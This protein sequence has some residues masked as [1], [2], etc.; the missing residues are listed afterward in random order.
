MILEKLTLDNFGL[1]RGE[2][3]LNLAPDSQN[4][5]RLPI[6]LFGGI[7]GGGKTTLLDAV[8][9]VLYGS[10][11]NYSKRSSIAYDEFLRGS[12]NR[13]V[14]LSTGASVT[15]AFRITLD[16]EEHAYEVRRAW[17]QR[18]RTLRERTFVSKDG[19]PDTY[20]ADH[21]TDFVEEAI[22]LGVSQ[23]F[24]FDAEQVRFL[25]DDDTAQASLGGAIKSLLGLDLAERL[26]TD[27]AVLESRFSVQTAGVDDDPAVA[28]F[29]AEI[30]ALVDELV[31]KKAERAGLENNRQRAENAQAEAEEAF[32]AIGGKHWQQ[33]DARRL[34]L[35][36]LVNRRGAIESELVQLAAGALPLCLIPE[37][38]D[39]VRE[40]DLRE[41]QAAEH[42]VV[43]D[44]LAQRDARVLESLAEL[45]VANAAVKTVRKVLDADRRARR[46]ESDVPKWVCFSD[47]ARGQLHVLRDTQMS[48][49]QEHVAKLLGQ[50]EA[51][52]RDV[53]SAEHSL[54]A[55]PDDADV[56]EYV[57]RLQETTKELAVLN[58]RA[59]RLDGEIAAM[60]TQRDGL[61]Q[62]LLA[63]RRERV[64]LELA[65]EQAAR[66]VK[67]AVRTQD[68][69]RKF[70][71][72]ATAA[73]IDRLSHRVT[74]SFRFL[75]R[76][77]TLVDHVQIDPATFAIALFDA[78]G[79]SI[80]KQR[81]SEGEKQVFAISVLWGLAQASPRPLPAIID[82]PMAR[83]DSEHRQHLVERYFPNA[84]HQVIILSTDTEVDQDFYA[85]LQP[86]IAR[87][88]H[89]DYD[90]RTRVTCAREGYF[91]EPKAGNA[92]K[93]KQP[94]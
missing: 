33:R 68:T 61:Q 77:K 27:A 83:L 34:A 18:G 66:M 3:S 21:W 76:K 15:L 91:W 92:G 8:K 90:E 20:L 44:I 56:A 71:A 70:L 41:K 19:E 52:V 31:N 78:K 23:L 55:I 57:R 36:E 26:I 43:Q 6:V 53:E 9:L 28:G 64:E 89:L 2:Q 87:A 14:P 75:L 40:Q 7:N 32:A 16:G 94:R 17:Y 73:K 38:L 50:L 5:N 11:G 51:I 10:R 59:A 49:L 39:R 84:S 29:Q 60:Q 30:E 54:A 35:S 4:G 82:T 63:R 85:Q 74:E 69:M 72:R 86:H 67:V 12:V 62:K 80:P 45:G 25:A 22:P 58:D 37:A 24:F 47:A 13:D 42:A 1:Y 93:R 79:R 46:K 81:L 48:Q 88:Y 65:N